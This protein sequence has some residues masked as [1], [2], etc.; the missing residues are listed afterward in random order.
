MRAFLVVLS[1]KHPVQ[2]SLDCDVST[3]VEIIGSPSPLLHNFGL[4][5]VNADGFMPI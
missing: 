5:F 1:T 4:S 2:L 3:V